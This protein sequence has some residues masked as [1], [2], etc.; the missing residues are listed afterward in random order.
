MDADYVADDCTVDIPSSKGSAAGG[1]EEGNSRDN[2]VR[3]WEIQGLRTVDCEHLW[4]LAV[5]VSP[6]LG[7]AASGKAEAETAAKDSDPPSA[8]TLASEGSY[9]KLDNWIGLLLTDLPIVVCMAVGTP[10]TSGQND[11]SFVVSR[12]ETRPRHH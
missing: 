3:H 8:L 1:A 11:S 10:G 6:M 2:D 12:A 7:K 4:V 9:C 5:H